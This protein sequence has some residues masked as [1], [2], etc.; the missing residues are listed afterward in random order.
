MYIPKVGNYI[1]NCTSYTATLRQ[2][3]KKL[4]RKQQK[5][6][7]I[8]TLKMDNFSTESQINMFKNDLNLLEKIYDIFAGNFLSGCEIL[9]SAMT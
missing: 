8:N 4:R 5:K 3:N 9:Q 1:A 7:K 2:N 6:K